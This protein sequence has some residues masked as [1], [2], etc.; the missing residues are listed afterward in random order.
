MKKYHQAYRLLILL[1]LLLLVSEIPFA[2]AGEEESAVDQARQGDLLGA[3]I[4]YKAKHDPTAK[5]GLVALQQLAL[6]V[7]RLGLR[8]SDPHERNVVAGILGRRGDS[9]GLVVLDEALQSD[10]PMLRRTAADAL[11]DMATPDAVGLLRR[12]YYTDSVGKRLAL[13]GLRRTRDR[14]A[15]L[16]YL[17]AVN[18]SDIRLR[19]QGAGGLGELR[20]AVASPVLHTLLKTEKDPI[21]AVTLAWSL[22]ATGDATGLAY[23]T[24]KLSDASEQIR[25]ATVGL[26]GSLDDPSIVVLLRT[27][28]QSDP[29]EMV[30]TTA[31]ASLTHFKDASGL[32]LVQQ[33]LEHVDFRIRLAA[34]VSFTRMDYET[35]KPLIVKALQSRDPLTRSNA[36]QV[37]GQNQDASVASEV[38]AAVGQE[39]DLYAKVQGL[40]TIGRIGG[41]ESVSQLLDMLAAEEET[42]RHA[43]AEALVFISDRLLQQR[44]RQQR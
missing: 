13:S 21:V 40:W 5:R 11:G 30:R 43:S 23:L 20:S 12:L 34:S 39:R 14:T 41:A 15:L 42:M 9:A 33:A 29:S 32:P 4:T 28:L 16:L 35:A 18:S 36:Y 1:P 27:V 24:A 37:I 44:G 10:R 8:L 17:D 38:I 19:T 3:V 22:A 26:L 6:E 2:A 7:L 25:D 31:A